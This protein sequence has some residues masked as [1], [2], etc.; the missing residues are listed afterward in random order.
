LRLTFA[1]LLLA[2]PAL[3]QDPAAIEA[4]MNACLAGV[5]LDAI[6][7]RAEAF[8]DARGYDARVAELCAAGDRDGA[9]A[10]AAKV[11]ADFYARDADAAR[12]RGCVAEAL[13]HDDFRAGHVCDE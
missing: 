8:A 4:R 6:G 9:A 13:G 11:E 12:M 2:A 1:L 10:F 5:D 7:V 3:A